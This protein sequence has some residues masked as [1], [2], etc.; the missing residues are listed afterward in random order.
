LDCAG[1]SMAAAQH[2]PPGAWHA[3]TNIHLQFIE[4]VTFAANWKQIVQPGLLLLQPR[5]CC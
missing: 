4:M 2:L 1:L 5:C 3:S